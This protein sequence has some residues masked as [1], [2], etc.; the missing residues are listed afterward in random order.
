MKWLEISEYLSYLMKE[1][2][3]ISKQHILKSRFPVFIRTNVK[4]KLG[5][6]IGRVFKN[7][8]YIFN[9]CI[10]IKS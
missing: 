3:T 7:E 4:F 9:T 10:T 2:K 6:K 5:I 8:L 1:K